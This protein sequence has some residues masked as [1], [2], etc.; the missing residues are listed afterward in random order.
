MFYHVKIACY[1]RTCVHVR[2]CASARVCARVC[3]YGESTMLRILNNSL[4]T[5]TYIRTFSFLFLPCGTL[6]RVL[7][8]HVTWQ[9]DEHPMRV[10]KMN[11]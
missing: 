9:H 5:H 7:S 6:F 2:T 4:I 1:H 11:R 8:V 3:N 10:L